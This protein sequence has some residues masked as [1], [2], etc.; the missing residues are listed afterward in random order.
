MKVRLVLRES[1]EALKEGYGFDNQREDSF[2]FIAKY[3]HEVVKE[4]RLIESSTT[5]NR[6]KFERIITEAIKE[7]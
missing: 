1:V 2:K 3:S 7:R 4:D 6:E 5:W